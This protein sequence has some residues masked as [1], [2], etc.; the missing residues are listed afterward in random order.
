MINRDAGITRDEFLDAMTALK[1]GVGVHYPSI[2]GHPYYQDTFGWS[3]DDY[4]HAG[5]VGSRT[6]SIPLSPR[7][8]DG[9]AADVI[10]AIKNI[11]RS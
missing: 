3:A 7:V 10:R 1:I 2:A 4:P 11:L 6:V 9:D 8:K 5:E